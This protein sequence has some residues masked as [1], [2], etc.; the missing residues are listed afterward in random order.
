MD[1]DD[2]DLSVSSETDP[3]EKE[4]RDQEEARLAKELAENK[5]PDV[6]EDKDTRTVF[7]NNL[8]FE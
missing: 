4:K 1:S 7:V 8:N 3:I 5:I 2:E 6:L